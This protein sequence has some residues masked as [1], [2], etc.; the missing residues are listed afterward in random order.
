MIKEDIG[1][2]I[3]NNNSN[4]ISNSHISNS[5]ENT[6]IKIMDKQFQNVNIEI[7]SNLFKQNTSS[8]QNKKSGST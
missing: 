1:G 2:E 6:S 7:D 4:K 3:S 8:F 5:L